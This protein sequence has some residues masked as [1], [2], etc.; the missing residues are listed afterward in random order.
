MKL[1]ILCIS[2]M[3]SGTVFASPFANFVG[4]YTMANTPVVVSNGPTYCSWA[5]FTNMQS[6]NIIQRNDYE[7]ADM[8]STIDNVTAHY[9]YTRFEE[10]T[11]LDDEG[12]ASAAKVFGDEK[13]ATYQ[14]LSTFP[15]SREA[16]VWTLSKSGNYYHFHI[17]Y[18]SGSK[19]FFDACTFD[20]DLKKN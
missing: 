7:V 4:L 15:E 19:V 2:L 20:V 13:K 9:S 6:L 18:Q 17:G 1:L 11:Y 16:V 5:G 14:V 3:S 12:Y 10:Y 8:V